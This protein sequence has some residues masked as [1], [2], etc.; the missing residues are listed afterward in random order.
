MPSIQIGGNLYPDQP[1]GTN[2]CLGTEQG[3]VS[4]FLCIVCHMSVLG[5]IHLSLYPLQFY[6]YFCLLCF[7]YKNVLT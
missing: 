7:S 4:N 1:V 3:V 5:F 2:R 6:Y